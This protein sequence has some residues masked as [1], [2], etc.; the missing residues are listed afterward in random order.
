[1]NVNHQGIFLPIPRAPRA[2]VKRTDQNPVLWEDSVEDQTNVTDAFKRVDRCGVCCQHQAR[3]T[4][5]RCAVRYCS[6][7]CYRDHDSQGENGEVGSCTESF[8]QER[9]AESFALEVKEKGRDT[10]QMLNR[11]H[12]EQSEQSEALSNGVLDVQLYELLLAIEK[13]DDKAVSRLMSNTQMKAAVDRGLEDEDLHDWVLEPWYPWWQPNVAGPEDVAGA[14]QG[15]E[16]ELIGGQTLD[17]HLISLPSFEHFR[18]GH[19]SSLLELQFNLVDILYGAVW[20]F[21]LYLGPNN[22]SEVPEESATALLQASCVLSRD[23]R[24]G[25]LEEALASCTSRSTRSCNRDWGCNAHWKLLA[26]DV[27]S[28]CSRPRYTARCLVEARRLLQEAA[29][30]AKKR[31]DKRTK[32]RLIL[33]QKKVEFYTSWSRANS[34]EVVAL[35]RDITSWTQESDEMLFVLPS[36]RLQ[37]STF[38][39]TLI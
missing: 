2:Q 29:C 9:V 13:D 3:Y 15:C 23:A 38:I 31:K 24:F 4:C 22:A 37:E 6:V 8:Y 17:D 11:V 26:Q 21:R 5:P 16:S 1:M 14:E 20:T 19:Q 12:N 7:A 36:D 32:T 30:K 28:I 34:S 25:S 39:A 35:S 18:R 10:V 27:A 33:M